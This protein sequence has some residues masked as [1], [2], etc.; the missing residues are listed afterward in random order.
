[1]GNSQSTFAMEVVRQSLGLCG[2]PSTWPD[3]YPIALF[4]HLKARL[5]IEPGRCQDYLFLLQL[6]DSPVCR[7]RRLDAE[8]M[9]DA[10]RERF[11]SPLFAV[12]QE[13][14]RLSLRHRRQPVQQV[15]LPG[16]CAE[17]AQTVHRGAHDRLL[18]EDLHCFRTLTS[19]RPTVA[20]P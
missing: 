12:R 17:S 7:Q 6:N 5:C 15:A 18:P 3:R 13:N 1:M 4:A 9:L 14:L 8:P 10:R 2:I 11:A 20:R 19:A 16:M